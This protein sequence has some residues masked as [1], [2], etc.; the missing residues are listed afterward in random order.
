M[1][2]HGKR[3]IISQTEK[4][5]EVV[6]VN[7]VKL[8]GLS[9]AERAVL[10]AYLNGKDYTKDKDLS[11]IYFSDKTREKIAEHVLFEE[12][13]IKS[14]LFTVLEDD[15][16]VELDAVL[17]AGDVIPNKEQEKR[18]FNYWYKVVYKSNLEK[19]LKNLSELYKAEFDVN[20]KNKLALMIA[21]K[22]KELS[23]I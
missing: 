7:V 20:E 12:G 19:D 8:D 23:K 3:L 10:W 5:Q 4:K 21:Q 6:E 13:D 16:V 9:I 22:T 2:L 15:D 14:K 11:L 17:G 18:Y 1:L